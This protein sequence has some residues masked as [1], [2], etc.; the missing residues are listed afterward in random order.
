MI[1]GPKSKKAVDIQ[2]WKMKEAKH[3]E[4]VEMLPHYLHGAIAVVI[5]YGANLDKFTI[6]NFGINSYLKNNYTIIISKI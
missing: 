4:R 1:D 2:D 6:E 5:D 3:K